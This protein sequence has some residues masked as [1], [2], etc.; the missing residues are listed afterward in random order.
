MALASFPFLALGLVLVLV[1]FKKNYP[2]I[3]ELVS[4]PILELGLVLASVF[5]CRLD[6]FRIERTAKLFSIF[7]EIDFWPFECDMSIMRG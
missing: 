6:V 5:F 1:L 2:I 7:S 4:L 3:L